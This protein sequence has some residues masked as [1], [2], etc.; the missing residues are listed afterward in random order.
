MA[1]KFRTIFTRQ[2]L[3]SEVA[4]LAYLAAVKFLVPLLASA[5]FGFHRDEFLYL[6]MGQHLDW[7]YLE[8]PPSIAF[9]AALSRWL[10]GG[11][12]YAVHFFP[13]LT[14]ALTLLLT[15]LIARQLG[16]GR[17]AQVLAALAYLF[18]PVYLHMNILFQP[19]T[20]DLFYFVLSAYLIIRILKEDKPRLWVFLGVVAGLGLLN[21][22][23]M[24]LYGFGIA[25]S[26]L[27]TPYRRY[28]RNRWLWLAALIALIICLPN[29]LWQHSQGWPLFEHMRALSESQ[30]VN[31]QPFTFLI[32]QLLMNLFASPV[33]LAGLFFVLFSAAGRT[34]RPL[35]WLYGAMLAVLLILSGKTYYLAPAYPML[36]AA[37]AVVLERAGRRPWNLI[38]R[39][40]L[41]LLIVA[42]GVMQLPIGVPCLPVDR[43]IRFFEFGSRNMG[44]A[45]ILRWETG[46][47]HELPQDWADMLGWEEQVAAVAE[48]WHSLPA[49]D[50][51]KCAIFAS[52][53]GAAGAIDYY[54]HHYGLP[55]AIC[56]TS[57]YW[58]WGYG[59]YTGEILLTIGISEEEFAGVYETS[60]AGAVF[61]YPHAREDGTPIR[62]WRR[63]R[64]SLADI[65][66]YNARNRY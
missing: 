31:V 10:L 66:A 16:G 15:G 26:L 49:E 21:K 17:F 20:F 36:M 56:P 57:S 54:G 9:F 60:E 41:V 24:L 13:A 18:S 64:M 37:G 11:S 34:W 5:D 42:G 53:Y 30:L 3:L 14:G 2:V 59:D 4:V 7:G 25:V 45:E 39:P 50:R 52:N 28:Y 27:L 12:L 47:F 65:W 43:M 33:W 22:Y 35:G 63:P 46:E 6:A 8:V 38:L 40:A 62:I 48:T 55:K 19:V 58:L 32:G 29:L 1:F 61:S 23:T 51:A 44:M